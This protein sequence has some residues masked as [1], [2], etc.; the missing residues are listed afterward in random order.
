MWLFGGLLVG[1]GGVGVGLWVGCLV[2]L[3]WLLNVL[4]FVVWGGCLPVLLCGCCCLE[5][6][7]CCLG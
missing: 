7:W 2:V 3:R 4:V 1:F 6:G 5:F